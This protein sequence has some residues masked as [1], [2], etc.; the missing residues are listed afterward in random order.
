MAL[1]ILLGFRGAKTPLGVVR[2]FQWSEVTQLLVI[3]TNSSSK[4]E[5]PSQ[6]KP[7]KFGK[8]TTGQGPSIF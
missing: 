2:Q 1:L 8:Q 3:Y 7:S 4:V 5:L 6:N